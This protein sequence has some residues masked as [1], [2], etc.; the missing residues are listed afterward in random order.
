[1][2]EVIDVFVVRNFFEIKVI[3]VCFVMIGFYLLL[4]IFVLGLLIKIFWI[5]IGMFLKGMCVCCVNFWLVFGLWLRIYVSV[6]D[7]VWL[8][9]FGVFERGFIVIML[10]FLVFLILLGFKNFWF[11]I[12]FKLFFLYFIMRWGDFYIMWCFFEG[13][14]IR[15]IFVVVIIWSLIVF[16]N[17]VVFWCDNVIFFCLLFFMYCNFFFVFL[18]WVFWF[19]LG[20]W[21]KE[22]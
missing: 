1:M 8:I 4:W 3:L 14:I 2:F 15:R 20:E 5:G 12:G 9:W 17:K 21:L 10:L 13:L 16:L 18:V 7:I 22:L 6:G 19:F 11:I